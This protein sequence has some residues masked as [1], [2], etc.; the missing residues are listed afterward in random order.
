[1]KAQPMIVAIAAVA[2]GGK[3]TI[4]RQLQQALP[5][6]EA[7]YFD[8]RDYDTASGIDDVCKWVE[9]GADYDLW[10]LQP[11]VQQ[12]DALLSNTDRPL[13]YIVLDYAFAYR[14]QQMRKFID[15]AIFI[16]TPLDIALARRVLRDFPHESSDTIRADMQQYL[17]RGRHAYLHM[18]STIKPDSDLIIDG[19]LPLDTI[20][21]TIIEALEGLRVNR[22]SR[23]Q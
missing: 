18:L 10:D 1:M 7:L 21:H 23:Q 6:A 19:S 2:G 5:N 11:L 4:T 9:D 22:C 17:M 13:D 3:T 14:Q 15:Y 12:L 8:D 20:V 16:D